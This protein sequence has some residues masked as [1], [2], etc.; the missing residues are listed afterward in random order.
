MSANYKKWIWGSLGWAIGGPIGAILG[1]SLGSISSNNSLNQSNQTTGGDFITSILV[2]FAAVMKAD[3]IQKKSELNYIKKFLVTQTGLSN[4]KKLLLIFKN[5]LEQDFSLE[6][7]CLQ[8]RNQMDD[9]SKS[10][11]I[12]VL[13][14]LSQSD[15]DIHPLELQTINRISEMLGINQLDYKSI[16]SMFKDDLDSAYTVLGVKNNVSDLEI[17][18]AYRR[19]ANKYH[20]DK[21]AHL[22]EEFKAMSQEK[23]K[24]VSEAYHKIK[25]ERQLK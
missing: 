4:T 7:V 21:T 12:H 11:L 9:A 23:F 18:K 10:Q 2:L 1:Y 8:I 25:K 19:M 24:S 6:D 20:P 17:K 15:G 3:G 5:I 16:E 13:F 22:G 14:G